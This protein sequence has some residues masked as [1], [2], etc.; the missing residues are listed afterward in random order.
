[1]GEIRVVNSHLKRELEENEVIG[2]TQTP[3]ICGVCL[4]SPRAFSTSSKFSTPRGE[5]R[6]N[7]TQER[8]SFERL[9]GKFLDKQHGAGVSVTQPAPLLRCRPETS[10]TQNERA[11]RKRALLSP[12]SRGH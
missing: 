11:S 3:R 6:C 12:A 9:R 7:K 8:H 5:L 2:R 1:M 4:W 10:R